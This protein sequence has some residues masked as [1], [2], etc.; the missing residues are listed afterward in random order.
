MKLFKFEFNHKKLAVYLRDD[1]DESVQAEIFKWREYRS[2]ENLIKEAEYPII[3][4]G[5]HIGLFSLYVL[6]LNPTARLFALEPEK[7]NFSLFKKNL[8]LN[9]AKEVLP[10]QLALAGSSGNRDLAIGTENHNHTLLQS[11]KL[12]KSQKIKASSLADFCYSKGIEKISLIKMDIEGG[13]YEVFYS[14]TP[15]DLILVKAIIMEYHDFPEKKHDI[16]IDLLRQ[17]GFGVQVFPSSFEK[18]MGFIL[19]TNKRLKI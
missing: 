7:D 10:S 2:A 13:E 4:V 16:I 9:H 19:A 1:A 5:A 6:A 12:I 15:E 11:E 3:D 14:L 17:S 18:T 8:Q